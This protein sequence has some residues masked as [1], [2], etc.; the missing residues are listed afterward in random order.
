MAGTGPKKNYVV[1]SEVKARVTMAQVLEHYG[2]AE[3]MT[4]RGEDLLGCCPIHRGTNA[5]QFKVNLP[6][7]IYYCFGQCK[8]G[9]NILDFV[10]RMEKVSIREAALLL[11]DWFNLKQSSSGVGEGADS[12]EGGAKSNGASKRKTGGNQPLKF[13][14]L[15]SLETDHPFLKDSG[16]DPAT[17]KHF[18]AGYFARKGLMKGRLAIPIHTAEGVLVGYAGRKLTQKPGYK[19]PP[20]F[21]PELELYNVH[22]AA[23]LAQEALYIV[24]DPLDVWRLHQAGYESTVALMADSLSNEQIEIL[25]SVLMDSAKVTLITED[26]QNADCL[27]RLARQFFT[28]MIVIPKPL[29]QHQPSE[30]ETLLN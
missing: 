9:G 14:G 22:R 4:R 27:M 18:E 21:R 10:S 25:K 19:F 28:H 30:I 17:L 16:F 24:Q 20:R 23:K 12:K 26:G 2:L 11:V 1:F 7:N 29:W 3:D 15:K 6:K 13:T 8:S 5:T